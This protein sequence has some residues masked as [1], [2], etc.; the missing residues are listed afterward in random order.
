MPSSLQAWQQVLTFLSLV[1]PA[2][3]TQRMWGGP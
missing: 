1:S 3:V 2:S